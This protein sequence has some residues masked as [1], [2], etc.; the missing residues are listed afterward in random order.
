MYTHQIQQDVK[1]IPQ[2][3]WS[4]LLQT[5]HMCIHDY[6]IPKVTVEGI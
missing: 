4:L 5:C 1:D 6:Y 3:F 2:R